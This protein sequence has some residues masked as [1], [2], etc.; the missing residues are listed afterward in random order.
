[1]T[2]EIRRALGLD[3][4]VI[5]RWVSAHHKACECD[6][7]PDAEEV[8]WY[9]L[10]SKCNRRHVEAFDAHQ[11]S[12]LL[13]YGEAKIAITMKYAAE[14]GYAERIKRER[15]LW[16][17]TAKALEQF[18]P[19]VPHVLPEGN[20]VSVG[21]GEFKALHGPDLSQ[22]LSDAGQALPESPTRPELEP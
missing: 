2:R 13:G 17:P 11:L 18:P 16:K 5:A 15:L 10:C 14:S 4:A 7:P 20:T 9:G 8:W 21:D 12:H 19:D 3:Y 22:A 6:P 1:M